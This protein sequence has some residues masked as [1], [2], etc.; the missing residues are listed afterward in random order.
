[1]SGRGKMA[2][3]PMPAVRRAGC[4][5]NLRAS[6]GGSSGIPMQRGPLAVAPRA[7]VAWHGGRSVLAPSH[8][9]EP[10]TCVAVQSARVSHPRRQD[11]VKIT[12][13]FVTERGRTAYR[14]RSGS[15]PPPVRPPQRC[16]PHRSRE[17]VSSCGDDRRWISATTPDLPEPALDIRGAAA[18]SD[19]RALRPLVRL[20]VIRS[21][22]QSSGRGLRW[23]A[24]Q[25]AASRWVLPR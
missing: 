19:P 12:R 4:Q 11:F 5:E 2:R 20:D 17:D 25:P 21:P 8:E 14:D 3:E 1:M 16:G 10:P 23:L 24:R 6:V 22:G 13:G 9:A 18:S 15:A 7:L